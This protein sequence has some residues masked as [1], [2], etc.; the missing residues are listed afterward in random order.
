MVAEPNDSE[1]SWSRDKNINCSG[2]TTANSVGR[3]KCDN[4]PSSNRAKT[5][6]RPQQSRRQGGLSLSFLLLA[7][8]LLSCTHFPSSCE[9]NI[10]LL[11]MPVSVSTSLSLSLCVCITANTAPI[12]DVWPRPIKSR[13]SKETV[14]Y[15]TLLSTAVFHF[16]HVR[17]HC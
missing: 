4:P 12:V 13:P 17:P 11:S 7:F 1:L 6:N 5:E 15:S 14:K 10:V 9:A 3:R 16:F 8:F 2:E